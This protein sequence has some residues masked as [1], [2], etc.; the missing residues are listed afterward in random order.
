MTLIFDGLNWP[1]YTLGD[2]YSPRP[3]AEYIAGQVFRKP[4]VSMVFGAAGS[5][6]SLLLI[7]LCACVASGQPWLAQLDGTGGLPVTAGPVVFLDFDSGAL[8]MHARIKAAG[9]ARALGEALS[10][11]Y[12]ACPALHLD[13]TNPR[14]M[15]LLGQNLEPMKPRLIVVDNLTVV[16]GGADQN[17]G[18]MAPIMSNFRR[19]SERTGAAVV[20]VHHSNKSGSGKRATIERVIGHTSIVAALDCILF[21]ARESGAD[22]I[23]VTSAKDRNAPVDPFG[24]A[25]HYESQDDGE[26]NTFRFVGQHVL[27]LSSDRAIRRVILE[28]IEAKPGINQSEVIQ[29]AKAVLDAV[30]EKRIA[31]QLAYLANAGRLAVRPGPRN[32]K[33]YYSPKTLNPYDAA[34]WL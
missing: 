23:S 26:L 29:E 22:E 8:A 12:V 34:M 20:I 14:L 16:S 32:A 2:A 7:D 4:S 21:V 33:L 6:K 1:L 25:F 24:A 19:L 30:G 5:L 11:F 28:A 17:R 27:D 15:D 10:L 31:N 18:D 3:P 13:A 9:Q